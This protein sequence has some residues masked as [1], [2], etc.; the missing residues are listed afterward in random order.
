MNNRKL[1]VLLALFAAVEALAVAAALAQQSDKEAV[2]A[3]HA[4]KSDTS[5]DAVVATVNGEAILVRQ[6]RVAQ[7]LALV[8][9]SD[10]VGRDLRALDDRA[11]VDRLIDEVLVGQ[12]AE[13]AGTTVTEDDVSMAIHAGMVAPISDPSTPRELR[14]VAEALLDLY[15][16][17]IDQVQD[18]VGVRAAYRRWIATNRF[19][20]ASGKSYEVI[21]AEERATA[22]ISVN[23]DAF[24]PKN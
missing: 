3:I 13:R 12:A 23:E 16:L 19:V 21:A 15:G 1:L 8:G 10:A 22:S 24:G 14:A 4:L 7:A 2:E 6:I 11:V 17:T 20:A 9:V 18:D 5:A